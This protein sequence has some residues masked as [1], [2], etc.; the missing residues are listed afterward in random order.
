MESILEFNAQF[1]TD[2]ACRRY[3]EDVR[4]GKQPV[5]PH[6]GK[7][8]AYDLAHSTARPGLYK[9]AKCRQEFTVTVGTVFEDSHVPLPKWFLA[10]YLIVNAKKGISANQLSKLLGLTYKT[11]WFMAHRI[12][13]MME[14]APSRRM[15]GTV[16]VDETYVGG[17]HRGE[18]RGRGSESKMPVLALVQRDGAVRTKVVESVNAKTL[19][20]AIRE[21]VAPSAS[22]M[23][24]EWPS[25]R[26]LR[27]EFK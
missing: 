5:C 16:E 22:V 27:K 1:S 20:A 18:K 8:K 9:C 19:K 11:T 14:L 15:R 7:R 17:K 21:A 10:T 24:D 6:C 3:L 13:H 2:D 4:W 26:G 23:T 12:R 25:Y